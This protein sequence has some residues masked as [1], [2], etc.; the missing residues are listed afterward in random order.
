MKRY[1]IAATAL[2]L[3]FLLLGGCTEDIVKGTDNSAPSDTTDTLEVS[4]TNTEGTTDTSPADTAPSVTD[5]E[6]TEP[7]SKPEIS[8]YGITLC[9]VAIEKY[10]VV[11]PEQNVYAQ[12]TAQNMTEFF[13]I[14]AGVTLPVV[15]DSAE[16]TEYEILIGDT[17]RAE[18]NLT[19]SL[20]KSEYILMHRGT[21]LVLN[22]Y[23]IYTAAAAGKLVAEYRREA[24]GLEAIDIN[25]LSEK[26]EKQVY[27][28]PSKAKNVILM[29]GDGMGFNHIAATKKNRLIDFAAES[30]VY[31]GS[32]ITRS[33]SVIGGSAA[34]TDSAAAATALAT[35]YKTING[36][37]GKDA[38]GKNVQNVRELAQLY[39]AKTAIITTDDIT[40]ATPSGFLAHN[41][42]RNNTSQLQSDITA[43]IEGGL[44]DYCQGSV[45]DELT[46]HT[47]TALSKIGYTDTPFF[48]MVEEGY[49][50]KHSHNNSR[51]QMMNT[52]E[53][54]NDS[55]IYAAAYAILNGDTAL[56][57]TADHET[58]GL[59]E[60]T[61]EE[62]GYRYTSTNHTNV[63]VPLF[64]LGGGTDFF[65][66]RASENTEIYLFTAAHF[67]K[68]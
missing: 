50:D 10:K 26:E 20:G 1:I 43:L 49:I 22:G 11:I 42:S 59:I 9:G 33:Q 31:S 8:V 64:A 60:D 12:Y 66:D 3:V 24:V 39:G 47:S 29:I 52:V 65:R 37:I 36:Y 46:S 21:K 30:F 44:V 35:G 15:F 23:G 62:K 2:L 4:E 54:F 7:S 57:V 38:N 19:V 67:K 63:N 68:S 28:N 53:R 13:K 40:G 5:T 17:D 14:N 56:I 41:I 45:G 58:G 27:K 32:S 6:G 61:A 18:D 16:E 34:Y 25:E 48:M 51:T 55:I